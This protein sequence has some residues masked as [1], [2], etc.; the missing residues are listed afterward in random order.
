MADFSSLFKT[1]DFLVIGHRGAAGL[2]AENTLPSFQKAIDLDCHAVELDVQIAR[3]NKGE[4]HLLILH[5][6]KLDRTTDGQGSIKDLRF[7]E[8]RDFE[9]V[10]GE[11][12]PTLSEAL[13][14][15]SASAQKRIGV[16][17]EL[18]GV[19]TAELV[20]LE[21]E[22]FS[23]LPILVSS[24]NHAELIAFKNFAPAIQLAP[25]FHFWRGEIANESKRFES[26]F[27][28]IS[29]SIASRERI[30]ELVSNQLRPLIYTVNTVD[31]AN[32]LKKNGGLGIFTDRPDLF[33]HD[34]E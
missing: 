29:K 3:D 27:C 1:R 24:F 23:H 15:I 9:C 4:P 18:K 12:V 7:E 33:I 30:Q 11:K 22:R 5:D 19:G 13:D 25:L 32:Q 14:L 26:G 31:T 16:N 34:L 17:I 2:E 20:A 21:L 28:N 10:N 8:I 6:E